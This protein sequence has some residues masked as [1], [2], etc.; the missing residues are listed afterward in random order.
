MND[1]FYKQLIQESPIGY[2]YHKIICDDDGNPCDYE[3]IEINAVFEALTGLCGFEIIGRRV[4]E[5]LPGMG[6][7]EFDWIHLYGEVALNG[8]KKEFVQFSESL[9]KWYE[10]NVY[11]PE[12]FFF[13][14]YFTDITSLKK[15][16]EALKK[17]QKHL[18]NI[19]EGSDVG[20]WEWN[21]QTGESVFDEHWATMMGYTLEEILPNS[22][23]TW[24]NFI[25]PEDLKASDKLYRQVF[26]KKIEYFDFESRIK[27]KN[28]SWVWVHDRA[29]V[30]SWTPDGKPLIM[31]GT[32]ANITKL[33]KSEEELRESERSKSVLLS[34]LPGM[35]YRC[36]YNSDFTMKFI[37]EGCYKLTG[38]KPEELI[39]NYSVSYN[40]II[41]PEYRQDLEETWKQSIRSHQSIQVEYRI[42]TADHKEKWVWEQGLPIY[43]DE[44]E[45]EA[46]EGLIV[47]IT[48]RKKAE[49]NLLYLSNHDDLTGVYNRRFYEEELKRLDV[50]ENLPLTLVMADINGLKLINDSFGNA[51]G[52]ELLIRV[53]EV[54]RKKCRSNDVLARLGGDEFVIILPKTDVFE[55]VEIIKNLKEIYSEEKVGAI[56]PSISFGFETKEIEEENIQEIFKKAEDDMYRHK[57]YENSS[58]RSKTIDLIM[59]TL[60]EKSHREM[61]HSQR[62]SEICEIIAVKMN[63]DKDA[64][65][66]IKMIGLIHDIGKMGIDEKILNK[67]GKLDNDEWNEMRKHPEIGYRILSSVNEF[68][69][70]ANYILEHHERWDGK[71]YPK[72]LSGEEISLQARIVGVADAYDAM[73]SDRAYRMGLS[74]VEAIAEIKRCSGTQFDPEIAELFMEAVLRKELNNKCE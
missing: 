26:A 38:Y 42:L 65:N 14:C 72:G 10:I 22:I 27:H 8:S 24:L 21:I 4:S 17:S 70:M 25:H 52:D 69:E 33:K 47:D 36:L 18:T 31:S 43:N 29:K 58:T 74:E 34:N 54:L 3:F 2:A 45:L 13:I 68:S 15:T 11:S 44:N 63:L 37:S 23:D 9:N 49:K 64:I 16:D 30:T 12:K 55:V 35:S 53:A 60:Y 50:K 5:I 46:L 20:T 1:N 19:L 67:P 56:K 7:S 41:L 59:N 32:Y 48:E 39:N 40:D 71:G 62:V 66:Q 28:G 57:L 73:T 61:R 51:I 6:T